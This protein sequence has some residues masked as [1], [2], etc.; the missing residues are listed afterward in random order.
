MGGEGLYGRPSL[1]LFP[2]GV[3][4]EPTR[5]TI[6]ALPTSHHHPRPYRHDGY[7]PKNLPVTGPWGWVGRGYSGTVRK[8]I[9]RRFQPLMEMMASVR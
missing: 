9:A 4:G 8:L 1:L 6:K 5:A 2:D 3:V 7:A